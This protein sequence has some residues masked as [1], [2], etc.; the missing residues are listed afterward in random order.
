MKTF[1]KNGRLDSGVFHRIMKMEAKMLQ[2]Y[3]FLNNKLHNEVSVRYAMIDCLAEMFNLKV[4]VY[5]I[6]E[7]ITEITFK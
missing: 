5:N 7:N 6:T 2:R 1:L 3:H 4:S